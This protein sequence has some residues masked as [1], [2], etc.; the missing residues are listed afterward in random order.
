MLNGLLLYYCTLAPT[1]LSLQ[2]IDTPSPFRDSSLEPSINLVS[3]ARNLICFM[4]LEYIV[5]LSLQPGAGP[6]FLLYLSVRKR[7]MCGTKIVSFCFC[8]IFIKPVTILIIFGTHIL[9]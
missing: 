5:S 8:N 6:A 1:Q 7:T 9:Q 4:R 3:N 2:V